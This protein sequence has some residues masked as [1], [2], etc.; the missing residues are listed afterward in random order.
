MAHLTLA[1]IAN[2]LSDDRNETAGLVLHLAEACPACGA[3]YCEAE[4][5]MQRFKHW[6]PAVTILEGREAD[7]AFSGL[8]AAGGDYAAWSARVEKEDRLQTWAVAW[9]AL[10][11]A[12]ELLASGGGTEPRDLALLAAKIA[13]SLGMYYHPDS[14][15]DLRALAYAA[16]AAADSDSDARLR[17]VALAATALEN[18]T[19]DVAVER[20][21]Q[22]LLS[23]ILQKTEEPIPRLPS[24]ARTF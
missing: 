21:V 12:R 18:G 7:A 6:D 15:A 4:A 1:V 17:W 3:A 10:E 16:A 23:R 24:T 22:E 19:G 8:M 20:E 11:R 13:E 2:L 9:V 5:L 14:I